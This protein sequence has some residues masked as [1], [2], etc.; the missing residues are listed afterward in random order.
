MRKKPTGR[1]PRGAS[2]RARRAEGDA[3]ARPS[4]A[5]P[6]EKIAPWRRWKPVALRAA[7][8]GAYPVHFTVSGLDSDQNARY[9][10]LVTSAAYHHFGIEEPPRD[11]EGPAAY[12]V[13]AGRL[14]VVYD[15]LIVQFDPLVSAARR[16]AILEE[17]ELR[18]VERNRFVEDQWIVRHERPGV[19]GE[20]LLIAADSL[21]RFAEVQ[22]AWPNSV[23]EYLRANNPAPEER[24]WWLDKIGVNWSTGSRRLVKG[25]S[26]IVI[27]VLDDGVD[28]DHPNLASR[29]G[30]DPGKDFGVNA[31]DASHVDPRPKVQVTSGVES[32]YHGTLCAGLVCSDGTEK[33]FL[34]VAPGCTLVAVR[35]IDGPELIKE[36]W[37][38]DAIRY[39]TGV[40][41]VISCSW[42]GE[43]HAD[44][45]AALND[46]IQGRG[47]K[48]T[49]I[50]C[51][52]G[53][54]GTVVD[55]PARHGRAIAV[56]ACDQADAQ[57]QYSNFGADLDIVTPSSN[58]TMIYSTDVSQP[59]W[60]F[61]VG[62]RGDA[63]GLF[64]DQFGGTSAATAI[65]A[66]VG[67]L[68]FSA[69]PTL[70][71]DDLL[72]VLLSTALQIGKPQ[73]VYDAQGH[74][75]EFGY[76]RINAAEAVETAKQMLGAATPS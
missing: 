54:D 22:F 63:D 41:D 11:G 28:I 2:G 32:D 44:V 5:E 60:G 18:A 24:R 45:V 71:V 6:L 43:E 70:T 52:A 69:N 74:S 33:K 25:K 3:R 73:I 62:M 4:A 47:G 55:F 7:S 48:G 14:R 38:A 13:G 1:Q 72:G 40:A 56:G 61:N 75:Q 20:S 9:S 16:S 66:G 65:A 42:I 37:L 64:F 57:T 67:A 39:A 27:A 35:V 19:A 29:I 50:F 53:N 68:C 17:T 23:A 8:G 31:T 12:L 58:G 46:T 15:E 51:A 76:G 10:K 30:A 21:A 59:N 49:A 36:A 34:G 26:S